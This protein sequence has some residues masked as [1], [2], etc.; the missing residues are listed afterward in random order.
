MVVQ[1]ST[2]SGE[3]ERPEVLP[4]VHRRRRKRR[5]SGLSHR[6]IRKARYRKTSRLITGLV[7]AAIVL[8]V[9]LYIAWRFSLYEPPPR[10]MYP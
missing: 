4:P 6:L 9:T 1:P 2:L 10:Y 5:K 3:L 8:A 7:L